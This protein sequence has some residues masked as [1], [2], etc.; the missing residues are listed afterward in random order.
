MAQGRGPETGKALALGE[1]VH[2]FGAAVRGPGADDS[3]AVSCLRRQNRG[4]S[5]TVVVGRDAELAVLRAFLGEVIEGPVGLVLCG[6]AGIGK[7]ILWRAGVEEARGR[8][9]RVLTCRAVEA[10]ASLSYAGLS[11]LLGEVL[12]EAAPSLAAPRLRAL[13]VAL[14]LAEPGDGALDAHAAGLAVRDVLGV[15][16]RGGPVLVAIDD[17]QSLDPA[18]AG[19]LQVAFRRLRGEPI[20]VLATVRGA[21]GASVPLG[22]RDSLSEQR[23]TELQLGPLTLGALR[24]LLDERLD[25]QLTRSEL[26]RLQQASGGN[27]FFALEL[28]RELVRLRDR[29]SA[30]Q[31]LR[32]PVGLTEAVGARLAKLPEDASDVLLAVAALARPTVELVAAAQG[33]VQRVRTAISAAVANEIVELDDSRIRFTHP[34]LGSICYERAPVWKRRELHRALASVVSDIEERARHLALA[35]E[36]PDAAVAVELD[37]AAEHAAASDATAAAA[38][39]CELAAGLTPEDPPAYRRRVLRAAHYQ[40]L[41][42]E[43]DG[44]AA[45]L[46]GLLPQVPAGVERADVLLELL[47]TLSG[48]RRMRRDLFEQA[49]AAAAEDDV[50]SA[51]ILN[52]RAGLRLWDG[53]VPAGL[54]DARAAL[55]SSERA[56]DPG[57]LAT[58]IARVGTLE[59]YACDVTPGLL[60]RGAEIETRHG[61]K[62]EYW[63][64]PRFELARLLMRRG[65]IGSSRELLE[66]LVTNAAARGDESTR[67]M[68]R[69]VLCMLEWV[70]GRLVRALE[71]ATAAYEL[72]EELENPHG[73]LWVGRMKAL[74]EADLGLSREARASAQEGLAHS[75]GTSNEFGAIAATGVLGRIELMHANVAGA[76]GYLRGLPGRLLAA[77]MN[78]P[79]WAVWPD[80]IEA[81]IGAG[82]LE[83]ARA[84]L[85]GWERNSRRLASPLALAG[86]ERCRG[87]LATADGDLDAGL[88]TLELAV[89]RRSAGAYPLEL[90][91]TLLSLGTLRRRALQKRAAR[92][93]LEQ[94]ARQFEEVG[95][96]VWAERAR[97]E[98]RRISGRRAGGDEL[99]ETESRVAALAAEGLSNKQIASALFMGLS[100]VEAHLSR[101]YRKLGIGSRAALAS[102]LA[103]PAR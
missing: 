34:L 50:R 5:A 74:V 1:S 51:R 90:A 89:S 67:V 73:R 35:A 13:E 31:R 100:T 3:L 54:A 22:L 93:A 97:A 72:G 45:M 91:R 15:L 44:A 99:T 48:D 68:V 69:W 78:D 75:E 81:I 96:P 20:G 88:A 79:T 57:L 29:P 76:T 27:P 85:D 2:R 4:M 56:G 41:A 17:A 40:R 6:D 98:L 43:L 92:E 7:T 16:S 58:A 86:V 11:D 64:C 52:S 46:Q 12:D 39:L 37:R 62:L 77:G 9:G 82:D 38:E 10:E 61:L 47:R 80:A 25:V 102:R 60:E 14:L 84:G 26:G 71:H 23:L 87:L 66:Q 18:S 8:F 101:V 55:E 36:G 49:L 42:G 53:D 32:I 30:G 24:H 28:G 103:P 94:A 95:A 59:A 70:A 33:D 83:L 65:D 21:H 63:A 19:V